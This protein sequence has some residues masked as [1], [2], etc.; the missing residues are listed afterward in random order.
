M[1]EIKKRVTPC[2]YWKDHK[3]GEKVFRGCEV[4]VIIQELYIFFSTS[5]LG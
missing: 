4:R 3:N 2:F 5:Y 1:R